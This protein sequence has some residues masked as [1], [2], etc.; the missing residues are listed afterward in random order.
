MKR[1][2]ELNG[3]TYEINLYYT[4][5]GFS[6]LSDQTIERGYY[7]SI[8]PVKREEKN[9]IVMTSFTAYSGC[10]HLVLPVKRQSDKQYRLACEKVEKDRLIQMLFARGF[11]LDY[12]ALKKGLKKE[13]A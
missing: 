13:E 4:K 10:K 9:G 8:V 5:G 11:N 7:L 12:D 2:E 3:Q 6:Y 1:Y